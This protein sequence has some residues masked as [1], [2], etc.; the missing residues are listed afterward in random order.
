MALVAGAFL[1]LAALAATG[2]LSRQGEGTD[3]A[4]LTG[5]QWNLDLVGAPEAWPTTEG[6]GVVVA[7]VDSGV[8]TRHPDLRGRVVG[9]VDC[10]GAAG[11]ADACRPGGDTDRDG[12]GTHVAGIVAASADDGTGVAGVAPEVDLLSV[13]ALEATSCDRRPC[14]ASGRGADVAAG[15]R[16]AVA[17]GATVVN[18]SV[19][20]TDVDAGT[21]LVDAIDEAWAAGAVVVVAGGNGA[22]RTDLGDAPAVV[23]SAVTAEGELAPYSTGV[24]P[25]RWALSAPGGR[26]RAPGGDGCHDDDAVLSTL[27]VPGG[28][29]AAYGCLAGTSMAAPHVAGAAALLL[30]TGLE[31]PAVVDRL[32]A[33][34]TPVDGAVAGPPLLDVDAAV[35]ES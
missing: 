33:T 12:H 11:D 23:V 6:D 1:A 15:I 31:P 18:L 28:E 35:G 29:G 8:D 24:G 17:R 14:G 20:I 21:D 9:S 34:A 10:V 4:R 30:A 25:A 26:E 7:V 19:G 27:P 5:D 32:L 3:P 16:W 13:R 2:A 22:R